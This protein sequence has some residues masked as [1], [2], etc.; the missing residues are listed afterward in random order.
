MIDEA[1]AAG[2][3]GEHSGGLADE[4]GLTGEIDIVMGTMSKAIAGCG[5]YVAVSHI[6][7]DYFVNTCR[8]LIY[9]TALPHAALAHNLAAIRYIRSHAMMGNN[10]LAMAD[11]FRSSCRSDFFTIGKSTT[12]IIPVITGD[13]KR[14][15]ALKTYLF[16]NRVHVPAIRPPTVP[17]GTSRVRLSL[18]SG[19]TRE[20]TDYILYIL[21]EWNGF[22]A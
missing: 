4:T 12:Q 20:D 7:R 22:D 13:E 15:L 18:H 10:L 17:A 3:L 1:H 8:S 9:S 21:N 11:S 6:L 16:K 5:G 19:L 14:A 2:I